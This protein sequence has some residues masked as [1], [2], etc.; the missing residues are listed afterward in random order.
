MDRRQPVH[1]PRLRP[2]ARARM[3]ASAEYRAG[4]HSH[5]G[6]PAPES[7]G[8]GAAPM[9]PLKTEIAFT[10]PWFEIVGKTMREGEAPFYSLRL[11]DYAAVLALTESG[12]ILVVRQYRPAVEKHTLELPSGLVDPGETPGEAAERELLE[13]TGYQAGSL[14]VLGPMD[15]DTG[16]LGNR[17]WACV[18]KGVVR[19]PDRVP[20]E[21]IE[22][23]EWTR[24]ELFR[25]AADG[26]FD[27]A[28]HVAILLL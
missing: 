20:E 6:L 27:H 19:L 15:P 24:E 1:L 3:E 22:V 26:R 7:L 28:L 16:R 11:P 21:G 8:A 9:K 13:E 14:E 18:A 10:T 4:D 12:R 17:I 25:A 5:A 23:F 2:R